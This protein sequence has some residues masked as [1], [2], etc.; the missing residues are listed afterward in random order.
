MKRNRH[1]AGSALEKPRK[2][3]EMQ[4]SSTNAT[5]NWQTICRKRAGF[6]EYRGTCALVM[7]LG[8]TL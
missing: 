3:A 5:A 7:K 8:L 2:T 1:S 6:I 4:A